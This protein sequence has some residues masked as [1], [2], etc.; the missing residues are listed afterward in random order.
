MKQHLKMTEVAQYLDVSITTLWRLR[1][2]DASFPRPMMFG[3]GKRWAV[4]DLEAWLTKRR[5]ER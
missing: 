5:G 3:R 1:R 4:A 2:D